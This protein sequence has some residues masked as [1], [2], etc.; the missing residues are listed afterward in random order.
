MQEFN[1][2]INSLPPALSDVL[3]R[4]PPHIRER[5]AEIRVRADKPLMLC[6]FGENI[7]VN[8][9]GGVCEDAAQ[10]LTVNRELVE[11]ILLCITG[12]A[13]HSRQAEL[14]NGFVTMPG[15]HRV[16]IA[17]T[18]IIKDG[19]VS[20]VKNITSLNIRIA[21]N[22]GLP[23]VNACLK[24]LIGTPMYTLLIAGMPRSGKTTVLKSLALELSRQK[25]QVAIIDTRRE[26]APDTRMR[27]E[28]CDVLLGYPRSV[29]IKSA[30]K[31]LAPDVI[32]CDE[33]SDEQDAQAVKEALG[34]GV[35]VIATAHADSID[36]LYSRPATSQLMRCS[37][38]T[39]IAMLSDAATPGVIKEVVECI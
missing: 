30:V 20:D 6:T 23:P 38:F 29:G 17:A 26:I 1:S 14:V 8:R 18:A 33:L 39:H 34:A 25:K 3:R 36:S 9:Q 13:V 32:M 19:E 12:R 2:V 7:F 11:E 4:V 31:S 35:N 10:A 37:A 15:G 27:F 16:G 21:K 24:H 5:V 28:C 22:T